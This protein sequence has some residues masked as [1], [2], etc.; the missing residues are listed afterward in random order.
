MKI[1]AIIFGILLMMF[2]SQ[3]VAQDNEIKIFDFR[4][5]PIDILT[6]KGDIDLTNVK[7]LI[8]FKVMKPELASDVVIHIGTTKD[9]GDVFLLKGTFVETADGYVVRIDNEDFKVHKGHEVN[10]ISDVVNKKIA[11]KITSV[12]MSLV[13]TSTQHEEIVADYY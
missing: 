4:V 12:T 1:K 5:I 7:L 13:N 6:P 9:A 2:S 3:I 11:E 10:I 8:N